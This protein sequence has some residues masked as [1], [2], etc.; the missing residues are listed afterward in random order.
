MLE[1]IM[2]DLNGFQK[3]YDA[4]RKRLVEKI[5]SVLNRPTEMV[6]PVTSK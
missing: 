4:R 2:T 3:F 6:E 1:G 5:V